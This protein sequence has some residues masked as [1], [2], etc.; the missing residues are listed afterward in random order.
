MVKQGCVVLL[1]PL[2]LSFAML[3]ARAG[4]LKLVTGDDYLPY[5]AKNMPNGG[6]LTE[7]VR[8]SFELSGHPTTLDW[9]PWKRGYELT[10]IGEY[11]ATFPYIRKDEREKDFL[12]SDLVYGGVLSVYARRDNGIDPARH[13]SFQGLTY[14]VAG[15]FIVYKEFDPMLRD[16]RIKLQRPPSLLSCARMLALGRADFFITESSVGDEV[17]QQAQVGDKV[18]RLATPFDRADFY[19]IISKRHP[20]GQ[21]LLDSFNAGLRRLKASGEYERIVRR[22][23]R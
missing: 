9:V 5:T 16:A 14:C 7:I 1:A 11:D 23:L 21:A 4:P 8:R 15:G 17:L 2:L 22:K 12:F 3:G 18:V 10:R 20:N 13:D 6:M 19:L